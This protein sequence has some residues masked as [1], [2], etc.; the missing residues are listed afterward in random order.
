LGGEEQGRNER[1]SK[2]NSP[3]LKTVETREQVMGRRSNQK[4]T[5]CVKRRQGRRLNWG[6]GDMA[7]LFQGC[8]HKKKKK[9][10]WI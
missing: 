3:L 7:R 1:G 4:G 2:I 9:T 8:D 6:E 10:V 5:Y